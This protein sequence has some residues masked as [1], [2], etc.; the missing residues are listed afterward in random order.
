MFRNFWQNSSIFLKKCDFRAVQRSAP[1]RSRRELSNAYFLAKFGFDAAEN[2]PSKVCRGGLSL[3]SGGE[4]HAADL[5]YALERRVPWRR[6][7]ANFGAK[8]Q[9]MASRYDGVIGKVYLPVF[10][11]V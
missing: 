3:C 7:G 2:E 10:G 6:A 9:G 4:P 5:D 1:C 11:Q 8:K